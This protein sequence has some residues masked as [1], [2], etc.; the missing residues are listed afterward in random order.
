MAC[1]RPLG[2]CFA[3]SL[4]LVAC[5]AGSEGSKA[6]PRTPELP[7][8]VAPPCTLE[9]S[10]HPKARRITPRPVAIAGLST[11]APRACNDGVELVQ[12]ANELRTH[13]ASLG[14]DAGG[15]EAPVSFATETLLVES[16]GLN[17]LAVEGD[18]LVVATPYSC[19]GTPMA[20]SPQY[21]AVPKVNRIVRAFCP[22]PKAP[23][24]AP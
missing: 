22:R 10:G 1:P 23:C 2:L 21:F 15:V 17:I 9:N 6:P 19:V 24:M 11:Q 8:D 13:V 5:A 20:C 18:A 4:V 12:S 7:D 3:G 14:Q 16:D